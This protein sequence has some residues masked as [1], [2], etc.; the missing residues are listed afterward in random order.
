VY[1]GST[2]IQQ[3]E[4]ASLETQKQLGIRKAKGLG[5]DY[6]LWNEGGQSSA[7]DDLNNRPVLVSLLSLIES[8]SVKRLFVYNTD[9]LSRNQQTWA[10]IRYKLDTSRNRSPCCR[11]A[12]SLTRI[13]A[14][15]GDGLA[16]WV[17][18]CGGA[19]A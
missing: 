13:G 1:W 14:G 2:L 17:L 15:E 6:Q 3:E 8:G 16:A 19:A 11:T 7:H 9:R 10:V 18:R 12:D 4:G 5:V